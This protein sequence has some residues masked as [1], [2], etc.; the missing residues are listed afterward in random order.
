MLPVVEATAG[1]ELAKCSP[2]NGMPGCLPQRAQTVSLVKATHTDHLHLLFHPAGACAIG[3]EN[4]LGSRGQAAKREDVA[5]LWL[6]SA[7]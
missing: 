7:I 3:Q 5:L 4:T 2:S 1:V 6:G